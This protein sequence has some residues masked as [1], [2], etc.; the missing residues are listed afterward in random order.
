MLKGFGAF[1]IILD[2]ITGKLSDEVIAFAV[3]AATT[4]FVFCLLVLTNKLRRRSK[5]KTFCLPLLRM[6]PPLPT[7]RMTPRSGANTQ[8]H[9][10]AL[11]RPDAEGLVSRPSLEAQLK[12]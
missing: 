1:G 7:T 5:K 6:C 8:A 12:S 2:D 11:R 3:V 10:L 4:L 9:R